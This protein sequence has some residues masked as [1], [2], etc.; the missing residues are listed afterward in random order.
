MFQQGTFLQHGDSQRC[1]LQKLK[2]NIPT[3]KMRTK[4]KYHKQNSKGNM[5][6]YSS[7]RQGAKLQ[8]ELAANATEN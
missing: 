5:H 8:S 6:K 4:T 7:Q 3:L 1:C 2:A